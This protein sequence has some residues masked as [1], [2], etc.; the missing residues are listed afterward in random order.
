MIIAIDGPAGAGKSTVSRA[1]AERL[2]AGYLDT[3]AMYR[4]VAYLA[5]RDGVAI[6]DGDALA[7]L[8]RRHPPA[9]RPVPGGLAVVVDGRD[10]SQDIRSAR[11]T[12]AVSEVAAHPGVRDV[13]T[14]LQRAVLADG[15]WVCDGRDIGTTVWPGAELKVFL[16]ASVAERARRR[17]AEL[18]AAGTP[19]PISDVAA[20]IAERDRR[21]STRAA[22]PLRAATDAVRLDTSDLSIAEV[23]DTIVTWADAARSGASA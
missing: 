10:I 18:A 9:I 15:E 8:A 20:A 4:A 17:C 6:G 23:V 5:I 3:G 12:A 22:S 7:G 2:G 1:V 21:D 19:E 16:T 11:V 13:V 14:A